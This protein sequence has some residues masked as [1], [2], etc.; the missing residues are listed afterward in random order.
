MNSLPRLFII[1]LAALVLSPQQFAVRAAELLAGPLAGHT[2]TT[3]TR[4]WVETS[5]PA[6]VRI[7][8]WLKAHLWY[9]GPTL[10]KPVHLGSASGQTS[11]ERP[12]IAGLRDL[13]GSTPSFGIWDDHDFGPNNSAQPF[14][15]GISP[16]ICF[17][18]T[19]PIPTMECAG[20]PEFFIR[21]ASPTSSS[22]CWI[23]ATTVIRSRLPAVAR[24]S[25][26]PSSIG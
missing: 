13:V 19:G 11:N 8:Y 16:S 7:E 10:S 5:A 3:S 26:Q 22:S 4:I 14:R 15:I 17:N 2:T 24:C 23:T 1:L 21:S 20:C 18:V 25:V 9:D 6:D 12:H